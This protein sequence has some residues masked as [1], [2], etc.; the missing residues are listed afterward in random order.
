MTVFNKDNLGYKTKKYPLFLGD[1]LGL[2][3][4]VNIAYPQIE[5]LYQKQ[6]KQIWN[7]FEVDLSQDKMDM[8]TVPKET[9]DL[10]IKTLSWQHLADSVASKSIA[11][12]LMPYVTNSELEGLINLWAFF[13]TIHARTYSHIVKQTFKDPNEMLNNTYNEMSVLVRSEAIVK[14]FNGLESLSKDVSKNDKMKAL[15]KAITA[16]F[17]L[18]GIAFMSS[19]AVTFSIVET[20][21][22]QGI[23]QL[24]TLICRDEMLHTRMDFAVIDILKKDPEW[25]EVIKEVQPEIKEILD[26]VV[27]Q[28][29]SWSDYLFSEGR[30]VV[31]LNAGLLKEYVQYM[32]KPL[33][34]FMGVD[35]SFETYKENPLPYMDKYIDSSKVQTAAQELQ[36][37]AYN[38]GD[39]EDDT[40]S[41]DFDF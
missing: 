28:E 12:L 6:L 3:D 35:Y 40:D 22:F 41:L 13:E 17:A 25:L 5:D 30:Q 23:G 10:M 18:E 15:V 39:I 34:D 21:V 38:I 9:S 19:F 1:D 20:D 33:Y 27:N 31:G 16:L 14:A 11:G 26:S 32:A 29:L 37:T 24:V 36:L 7:E 4:T 2:F 8:L